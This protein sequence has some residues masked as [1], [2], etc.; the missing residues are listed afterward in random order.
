MARKRIAFD[1]RLIN[2]RYHGIGRFAFQLLKYMVLTDS[3]YD[4]VIYRGKLSDGRFIWND[5]VNAPHVSL[6]DGPGPIYWPHEQLLWSIMLKRDA[7]DLFYSPYINV[8]LLTST[9][10]I[11][12]VHDMIFERF[13]QYMPASWIRPYYK[14][15]MKS[16]L[17]KSERIVTVSSSTAADLKN[18]YSL[19]A[20]KISVVPEGVDDNFSSNVQP[21]HLEEIRKRYHL[22]AP[23]VLS[24]GACRPHKNYERLIQAFSNLR[25]D[26]PH[27]LVLVGPV[28][29]RFPDMIQHEVDRTG[30]NGRVKQLKWIPEGDLPAVYSLADLVVLPSIIEGFGLPA[31][32]A[33]ACGTPVI[34][35]NNSSYPEVV[36]DAGLLINP[37]EVADIEAAMRLL[38][39]DE[40]RRKHLALAGLERVRGFSW[41]YAAQKTL[42]IY[43]ELLV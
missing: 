39:G 30:L 32:E 8:P 11:M 17:R 14:F 25:D 42:E 34:A 24:V 3:D 26:F 16:G 20:E 43:R 1:A 4:F 36:G 9:P 12:T 28:D 19:A 21:F 10:V 23:Y 6:M 33:M 27:D 35:A 29:T 7:I 31:L 22:D 37:Y 18:F 41:D 40:E 15:L 38:L 13:P 5:I 2:D